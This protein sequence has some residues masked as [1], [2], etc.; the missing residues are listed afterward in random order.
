MQF[1]KGATRSETHCDAEADVVG[2]EHQ[3]QQVGHCQRDRVIG[4]VDGVIGGAVGIAKW[5]TVEAR[6]GAQDGMEV[7]G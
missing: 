6:S 2:H 7:R 3:H 5:S 1:A 4:S